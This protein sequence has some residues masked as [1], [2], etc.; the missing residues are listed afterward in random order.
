MTTNWQVS[1]GAAKW[2]DWR[3]VTH[4]AVGPAH[5]RGAALITACKGVFVPD[6]AE[7]YLPPAGQ[8]GSSTGGHGVD[9]EDCQWRPLGSI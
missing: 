4:W 2:T 7:K 1:V 9:C 5:S 8:P 6:K 3:G